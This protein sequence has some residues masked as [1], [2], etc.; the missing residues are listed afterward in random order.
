MI[1]IGFLAMCLIFGTTFLAI[2]VGI[3]AGALPFLSAGIRFVAAGGILLAVM[4]VRKQATWSLLGRK[5]M[6]ITGAGLTFGTFS[7]LYWAEQHISS[8]LA[9]VLSAT[10]PIMI[11]LLQAFALR[12]RTSPKAVAGCIVGFAGVL[13]IMLPGM[14]IDISLLWLAGCALVI[15]GE[16]CYSS[17]ALYSKH[18]MKRFSNVS[19][20][21][22][23]AAQMLYGGGLLMVLSLLVERPGRGDLMALTSRGATG[24]LLYLIIA[25]SMLGHSLF[26]WLVSRTNPVFPSTWLYI[27]PL[28]ALVLG[29]V[30]YDEPF[31][32]LTFAGAAVILTGII[33]VNADSLRQMING[34]LRPRRQQQ[35]SPAGKSA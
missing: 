14:A 32:W 4:I 34:R 6:L 5:E 2:R 27:S 7:T 35:P 29:I 8:G 1:A 21:A 22:M 25:G 19:P 13:L 30:V 28:I 31:S 9:A 20:I 23:N 18:V 16:F 15:V 33:L 10:G 3:D 11:L 17:G 24:S 26:Y 12:Q